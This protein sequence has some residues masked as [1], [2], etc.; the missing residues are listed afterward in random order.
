MIPD[1]TWV[2]SSFFATI[3]MRSAFV[4][5]LRGPAG[6]G[7]LDSVM[8]T[9]QASPPNIGRDSAEGGNQ[10]SLKRKFPEVKDSP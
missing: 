8:R 10:G 4:I 7:G 3:L 2:M 5:A 1:W 9:L 6:R